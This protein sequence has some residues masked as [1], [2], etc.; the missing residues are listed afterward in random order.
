MHTGCFAVAFC[1]LAWVAHAAAAVGDE[2]QQR[3]RMARDRAAAQSRY[4]QAVRACEAGFVVSGCIEKAKSERRATLD[5][6]AREQAT[7]DDAVRK[8]RAEERRQRIA[9]KQHAAAA[10]TAASA[11]EVQTRPPR[12]AASAASVPRSARKAEPR[13]SE[14]AA[15]AEAE[16]AERSVQA[17][18]RRERA[19]AHADTVRQ[20]NA[21]RALQKPPAAPLPVPSGSSVRP[22]GLAVSA[23]RPAAAAS[24]PQAP[25]S[26]AP[27]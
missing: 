20:R 3:E 19:Q 24:R 2:G 11:P 5:R 8:R 16:A 6:L 12:P 1:L 17:Q 23:A 10:R 13:S 22:Q 7:L 21:E 27:E 25:A 18:Q 14:A 4:E 9:S 26:G 15:A